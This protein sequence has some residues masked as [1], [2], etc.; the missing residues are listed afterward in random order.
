MFVANC[1]FKI[2]FF[3]LFFIFLSIKIFPQTYNFENFS[4]EDGLAQNQV[5][6]IFQDNRGYLWFGTNGGGISIYDGKIFK[7]ISQTDSLASNVVFFITQDKN[8]KM[9][10]CTNVGLSVYNGFKFMNYTTEEGLT[11]PYVFCVLEDENGDL[12]LGTGSGISK[13]SDGKIISF[14]EDTDSLLKNTGV[15]TIFKDSKGNLPE[16]TLS[17]SKQKTT[18]I[19]GTASP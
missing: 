9:L 5:L 12:L 4:V 10:F 14:S 6:S 11:H 13:L 17:F 1:H 16:N 19:T 2:K 15:F 18:M 7:N 3:L 8:G